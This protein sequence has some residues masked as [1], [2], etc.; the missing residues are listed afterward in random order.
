[1]CCYEECLGFEGVDV[2]YPGIK[3]DFVNGGKSKDRENI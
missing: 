1:M 2:N 3:N